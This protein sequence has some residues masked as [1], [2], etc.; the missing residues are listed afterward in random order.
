M[1]QSGRIRTRRSRA[2]TA[3][4]CPAGDTAATSNAASASAST[5][6]S[7]PGLTPI[8]TPAARTGI[9][10]WAWAARPEGSSTDTSTS[11][12]TGRVLSGAFLTRIG[13][14][15]RPCPSVSGSSTSWL[16]GAY[17][18][19]ST[20]MRKPASAAGGLGS[21]TRRSVALPVRLEAGAP[22][23]HRAVTGSW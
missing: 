7:K 23:R 19:P 17:S 20:P 14:V 10:T 5:E 12:R 9:T 4:R 8:S 3:T 6:P 21:G 1:R 15:E 16:S 2:G 18:S 11:A 13:R 22:Y